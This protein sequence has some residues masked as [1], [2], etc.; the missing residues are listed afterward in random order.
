VWEVLF[1]KKKSK[2]TAQSQIPSNQQEDEQRQQTQ[3]FPSHIG[4]L[5]FSS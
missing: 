4:L 2:E 1:C 3:V 5:L